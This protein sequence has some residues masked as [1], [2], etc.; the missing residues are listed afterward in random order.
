MSCLARQSQPPRFP[1]IEQHRESRAGRP[2]RLSRRDLLA[3]MLTVAPAGSMSH[4]MAAEAAPKPIRVR[5]ALSNFEREPLGRRLGFKGGYMTEKWQVATYL[6]SESGQTAVGLCSQSVLWSDA[7][8]FAA[9]SEA[10]GNALMYAMLDASLRRLPGATYRDP[11]ELL[12]ETLPFTYGFGVRITGRKN[13]RET[14]ALMSLVSLDCAAWLLYAKENGIQTFHRMIPEPYRGLLSHRHEKVASVPLI[15]YTVPVGEVRELAGKGYF[16]LKIKIGQ[17]GSQPEMLE[18]DKRRL[19]Q[20]HRAVGNIEN[21]FTKDGKPRYYLDANGRYERRELIE[22]LL[23]HAEKIGARD[24]IAV[25]EEPFP[26]ELE[27]DVSRLGVLV[28][29]DESAHTDRSALA[30]MQM[31]YS[32]MA[33]KGAAKTL[34]MSLKIIRVALREGVPCF[35]ADSSAIPILVDWNKNLAARLPPFPDLGIG[36][37]ETNGHQYYA[38]WD[39]LARYHPCPEASWTKVSNGV[40]ELDDEF[41]RLSGGIFRASEHYEALFRSAR[42]P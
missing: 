33:I 15:S 7:A 11:I 2:R 41:Y 29:A 39:R 24:Q 4:A 12:E 3:A 18:K 16:F 40:F 25:I 31:G 1:R 35:C 5:R 6:E 10:A 19:E 23:D 36:L 27:T 28:A 21:Q 32:A 22:Q 37:L 13:L 26:E 20:I 38:D 17:P 9:H 8:V 34:S 30:R 14:F 42:T